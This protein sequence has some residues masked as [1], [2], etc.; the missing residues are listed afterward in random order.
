SP[1]AYIPAMLSHSEPARS[2]GITAQPC[3][4]RS[5][6]IAAQSITPIRLVIVAVKRQPPLGAASACA[7]RPR[8]SLRAN[9]R[10][11]Q[12]DDTESRRRGCSPRRPRRLPAL[13]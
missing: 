4:L 8:H 11:A 7:R 2:L 10:C 12:P 5:V 9:R 1:P 6:A 13:L 3:E